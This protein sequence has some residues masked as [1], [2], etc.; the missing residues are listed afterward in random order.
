V[1][2]KNIVNVSVVVLIFVLALSALGL[3]GAQDSA[4]PFLGVGIEPDQAGA[5]VD[6]I[7]ADSPAATAGLKVGDIITAVN[8]SDV[9]AE[10]LASTIQGLSVGDN[11][12]LDVLRNG[13]TLNLQA[14]LAA[15]PEE[16][17]TNTTPLASQP[18]LGVMLEDSDNG[19]KI[20]E[21]VPQ[22]P[23]ANADLQVN[24]V[25]MSINSTAVT[26]RD[27]AMTA[28]Q[29][30]KAGD[31]VS[32]EIQ[33]GDDTMTIDATLANRFEANMQ[34]LPGMMNFGVTYNAE[35]QSWEIN[36][37]SEDS[38]LYAA[39]LRQGDKITAFDGDTYDPSALADYLNGMAGDQNVKL[40]V[41]R[42]GESMDITVTAD[43]L[44]SLNEFQFGMQ[45]FFD[46]NN[47]PF[48]LAG[49]ARLGVQF[50]TL[51]EETAADHNVSV[52][53]G[54]LVTEVATDSPAADAGLQVDDVITAVN[55]EKVDAEHTL[56]DR[57]VAYEPGDVITLDVLRDGKTMSIEATLA[58]PEMNGNMFPFDLERLMP[59]F[60]PNGRF[61]F[62]LPQPSAPAPAAPNI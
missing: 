47:I 16:S 22:S 29:A 38:A 41:D 40:T 4:S 10:T 44:K 27:E 6:Q 26:T 49:T 5:L 7:M 12:T 17:T 13:E 51:D 61:Q 20:T 28:I 30:L 35:T 54:A 53:D 59:F 50:V 58:E 15:R 56:R 46:Q 60:G 39:G 32:L 19:V 43:A 1:N 33:R 3:V 8:G 31:K 42:S 25:I 24:D 18:F 36:A 34:T 62:E 9:T 14:A 23:A 45:Q 21:V 52:T 48:N 2:R 37:L 57:L 55:S 11:V